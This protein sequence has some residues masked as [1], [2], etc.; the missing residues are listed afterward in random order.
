MTR[1]GLKKRT[2]KGL[3]RK[4][5]AHVGVRVLIID[6]QVIHIGTRGLPARIFE[7]D[8]PGG[9]KAG[10]EAGRRR[11]VGGRPARPAELAIETAA[12]QG[13]SENRG[14]GSAAALD[15]GTS[16]GTD[17]FLV[18]ESARRPDRLRFRAQPSALHVGHD[19]RDY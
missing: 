8:L 7:G 15:V 19:V 10:R 17:A 2:K 12:N 3:T 4:C 9:D 1:P 13:V 5:H 16:E 14:T 11:E 6:A 18:L